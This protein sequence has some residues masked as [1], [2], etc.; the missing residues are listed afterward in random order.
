MGNEIVQQASAFI[1]VVPVF[2]LKGF[3]LVSEVRLAQSSSD[4][5]LCN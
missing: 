2:V 4:H 1:T 5:S 3:L